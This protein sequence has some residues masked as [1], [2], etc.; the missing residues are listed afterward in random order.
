MVRR[1]Y[2][3]ITATVGSG[4]WLNGTLAQNKDE[5]ETECQNAS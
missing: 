2:G 5:E 1:I 3:L 4:L